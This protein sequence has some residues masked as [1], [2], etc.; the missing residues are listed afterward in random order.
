MFTHTTSLSLASAFAVVSLCSFTG[1]AAAAMQCGRHDAV[2]QALASKYQETRRIMG[3]VNARMV[4]EIFMSPKGTWTVLITNTSGTACI[5]A[6]GE[7]WQELPVA[8]AGL[9]G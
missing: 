2:A 4:M 9:D 6:A 1:P 3:V 7:D 8:V 5:T